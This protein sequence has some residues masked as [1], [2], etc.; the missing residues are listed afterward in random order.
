MPE[1]QMH[2][3]IFNGRRCTLPIRRWARKLEVTHTYF[4]SRLARNMTMQEIVDEY[5]SSTSV[6]R[7]RARAITQDL[8]I[9][10]LFPI[11]KGGV[12]RV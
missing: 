1:A 9:K 3:A 7:K 11:N 5:L 10:F 2:T 6:D 8:R 4:R 12:H